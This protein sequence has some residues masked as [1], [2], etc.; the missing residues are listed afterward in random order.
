MKKDSLKDEGKA[1]PAKARGNGG[2]FVKAEPEQ[3]KRVPRRSAT[4]GAFEEPVVDARNAPENASQARANVDMSQLSPRRRKELGMVYRPNELKVTYDPTM[5]TCFHLNPGWKNGCC[6]IQGNAP[7]PFL[8][9]SQL[10][11]D[12]FEDRDPVTQS[13]K[14]VRGQAK[15]RNPESK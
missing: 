11:C 2:R 8:G 15:Y 5:D 14:G 3:P 13:R 7:C 1:A 12:K 4:V 6:T 9:G 10:M